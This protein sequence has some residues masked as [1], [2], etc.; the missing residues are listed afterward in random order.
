MATCSRRRLVARCT[1]HA[2][3]V[4]DPASM[5]RARL[6]VPFQYSS[7]FAR[8]MGGWCPGSVVQNP[9]PRAW[10]C[11]SQ[12]GL[13]RVRQSTVRGQTLPVLENANSLYLKCFDFLP[14]HLQYVGVCSTSGFV[15]KY[16]CKRIGARVRISGVCHPKIGFLL[17]GVVESSHVS[18]RFF[19][20]PSWAGTQVVR[21]C[22]P[23]VM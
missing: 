2:C 18:A 10:W 20:V 12:L 17:L 15:L 19:F 16:L 3:S 5:H 1:G 14:G 8:M 9:P 23:R 4:P 22:A 13:A 11:N 7:C 6:V 21:G